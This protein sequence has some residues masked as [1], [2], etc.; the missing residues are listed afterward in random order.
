MEFHGNAFDEQKEMQFTDF[1]KKL[2]RSIRLTDSDRNSEYGCKSQS[3]N[4]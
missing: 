3:S 2:C 4:L 1:D